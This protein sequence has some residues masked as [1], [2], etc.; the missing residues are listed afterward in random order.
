MG[1]LEGKVAIVTGGTSG[2]GRATVLNLIMEGCKVMI[3]DIHENQVDDLMD[4]IQG[5]NGTAD[6][7]KM[8]VSVFDD[9]KCAINQCLDKFGKLDIMVANAGIGGSASY[10]EDISE[11]E[12]HKIIAVNQTGVFYCMQ[13]AIKVM[14]NQGS[15]CIV[16]TASLAGIGSAPRMGA[17]AAS[18]HAVVGMTKTVAA[19]YGKYG[20]RVN[21]VCPSVIDTPMGQSFT[22][23]D[24]LLAKMVKQAIPMKRFGEAKEVAD[25]I[26][27]LCSDESSFVNGETVRIDGGHRA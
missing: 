20:I 11:E 1:K 23:E 9:V 7:M 3:C 19:E 15:G 10:F 24:E 25:V 18:K 8:D 2:I 13:E 14:K 26:T 21:A 6:F 17:Y 5:I 16:N 4:T 12:W 27:W 22:D